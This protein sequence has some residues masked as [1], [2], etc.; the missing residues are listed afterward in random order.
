MAEYKKNPAVYASVISDLSRLN[1]ENHRNTERADMEKRK[2]E[3][4]ENIFC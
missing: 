4:V 1:Q 2:N 3:K